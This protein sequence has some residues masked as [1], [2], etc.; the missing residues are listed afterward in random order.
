MSA[1]I[2]VTLHDTGRRTMVPVNSLENLTVYVDYFPTKDA[3]KVDVAASIWASLT[4]GSPVKVVESINR[5]P[6]AASEPTGE[7]MA[8]EMEKKIRSIKA[9]QGRA[10][11]GARR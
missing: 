2:N 10:T 11:M 1:F 6:E 7:A 3:E 5:V 4:D 9:Q 8:D